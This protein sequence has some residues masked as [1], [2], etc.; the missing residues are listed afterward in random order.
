M[1]IAVSACLHLSNDQVESLDRGEVRERRGE[2]AGHERIDSPSGPV[3]QLRLDFRDI[4][5]GLEYC[6][7]CGVEALQ[8]EG[9]KAKC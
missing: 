8:T 7:G 2:I 3:A 6:D 9:F 4:H 5:I 1:R